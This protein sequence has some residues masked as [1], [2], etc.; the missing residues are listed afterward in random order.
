MGIPIKAEKTEYPAQVMSFMGLELDSVEMEARLP[1]DKLY[2]LRTLLQQY[3]KRRKVKLVE[4]QSLLG[5]LN[6]CCS[7][8]LPGRSFMRRLS[9]LTKKLK[10]THHRISLTAESRRDIRAWLLFISHFNGKKLLLDFKW[11]TD[12]TLHLFTDAAGALGYGAIYSSHCFFGS[13]PSHLVHHQITF[14]ELFP[15]VLSLEIW[16]P[17]LMNKCI[18]L[19]S[20]NEAVV[21]KINMQSSK[22]KYIMVL[23]RR[24]VLACMKNNIL[25]RAAHIPGKANTLPDLLSR[26][27]TDK[28]RA[29]STAMDDMPSV[30][31]EHLL[32]I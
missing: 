22:D 5:L 32:E 19:H 16:G 28:F 6:F 14:K 1:N 13:W 17:Q 27:Q 11:V 26:L 10:K 25:V 24:L 18:I 21:Y 29:L 2:K 3:T 4:R 23:V 31:P 9:E 12:K 20:D 7:V 15:I 30:V 8:V